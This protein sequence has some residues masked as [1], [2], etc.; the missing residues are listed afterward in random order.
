MKYFNPDKVD[1]SDFQFRD[2]S[3][4]EFR[5]MLDLAQ[6]T[7]KLN[8]QGTTRRERKLARYLLKAYYWIEREA[9]ATV[10]GINRYGTNSNL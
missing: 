2:I 4:D 9:Y 10:K 7:L 8:R 6:F 5:G 3:A 1:I